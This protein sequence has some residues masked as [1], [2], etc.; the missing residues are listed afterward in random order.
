MWDL[1]VEHN[2]LYAGTHG[3]GL[4]KVPVADP[5]TCTITNLVDMGI[6]DCD[7]GAGTYSREIEIT[8]DYPFYTGTLDLLGQ[9]FEIEES[10]QIVRIDGLN[11]DG[12]SM[13]VTA[14]FSDYSCSYTVNTLFSNPNT[15]PCL[16]TQA[17]VDM[18]ICDDN[19]TTNPLDDF[20]SFSLD[21]TSVAAGS[22]YSVSG[23]VIEN[24]ISYGSPFT[25]DNGG[26]GYSILGGNLN[27]TITDDGNG[28]CSLDTIILAPL[29][30]CSDNYLCVD[31]TPLSVDGTYQAIGPDQGGGGSTGNNANWFSYT[32]TLNGLI[33]ISSC[34]DFEDTYLRLH[35]G[36][37]GSLNLI[38]SN[39]NGC[40]T[41]SVLED[42]CLMAGTNYFIEWDDTGSSNP[43]EFEIEFNTTEYFEDLDGDG[44]GN[45]LASSYEC[46][47]PSGYVT[48]NM[49]CDDTD[50]LESPFQAWYLDADGDGYGS[51]NGI[52]YVCERP[53]GMFHYDELLGD[54][55]DDC[56]DSD[57]SINPGVYDYCGDGIDNDCNGFI[58]DFNPQ[59]TFNLTTQAEV[60]N[61]ITTYGPCSIVDGYLTIGDASTPS[62]ITDISGLSSYVEIVAWLVVRNNPNL[63]SLEGLHNI[64]K[65]DLLFLSDLPN[66]PDLQDLSSL[67][68]L[69]Q[70]LFINNLPLITEL[71]P[72]NNITNATLDFVEI[73][74]CDALVSL[75]GLEGIIQIG[76][77]S[78]PSHLV[79]RFND[80]LKSLGGL[81]NAELID[82]DLVQIMQ[83][84]MLAYCDYEHLCNYINAGNPN[85]TISV[86]ATG[87]I[88]PAEI[89]A[90]CA[91][92]S[93]Y[94]P[95]MDNDCYGTGSTGMTSLY[96]PDP[97]YALDNTDCDDNDPLEYPGQKWY[98]DADGDT[99]GSSQVIQC[100]RP[101]NGFLSNELNGNIF[102]DCDDTNPNVNP[103]ML[104]ICGNGIDENC[105]GID[106]ICC[107][108]WDVI[109]LTQM[110]VDAFVTNYSTC[111]NI[112]GNLTIGPNSGLSDI[113]DLSG[114]SFLTEI[115]GNVTIQNNGSLPDL[116]G[117]EN[118]TNID[119][120]LSLINNDLLLD[121]ASLSNVASIDGVLTIQDND[122]LVSLVG[123]EN[124]D[125]TTILN[126][127]ITGNPTLAYCD[128]LSVCDYV[129]G[130]GINTINANATGCNSS[131]EINTECS[132][133]LDYYAD[134]D[135]D[136][137]GDPA[138]AT[139]F[140]MTPGVAS[141]YVLD[142]TDCND[143]D[144]DEFPGQTW[145]IDV[146]GDS[147]GVSII[148]QCTQPTNGIAIT[149]ANGNGTDDCNDNDSSINPGAT[150]ICDDGIDQDCNP[151]NEV[152][153]PTTTV[154]LETQAE[155]DAFVA[156]YPH[157]T[158]LKGLSLGQL[159][160]STDIGDLSGLSF[161]TKIV[162]P[163]AL[164]L[165]HCDNLVSLN[166][167]E[168]I[169]EIY[170]LFRIRKNDLLVDLDVLSNGIHIKKGGIY[171]TDNDA[172]I[173]IS[174]LSN[175]SADNG[176]N[177]AVYIQSNDIL[178]NL[179]GLE[180]VT[181]VDYLKVFDNPG[182]SSMQGL[183][184]LHSITIQGFIDNNDNMTSLAGLESLVT[185]GSGG[186]FEGLHLRW[187]DAVTDISALSNV[188]DVSPRL[189]ISG[190]T[191]LN[192][193]IG[194]Q[195]L[196]HTILS[197]VKIDGNTLLS[198]CEVISICDYLGLNG[199]AVVNNNATYCNT[200]TEILNQCSVQNTYY[201][202]TDMDSFGDPNNSITFM[203]IP[204]PSGYV[205]D[206]TD[207]NDMD[208]N[209]YPGQTWYIDGDSDGFGGSTLV[210]C[211]RPTNGFLL[212][213]L[214]G[215]G[216]DDC[217]DTDPAINPN[218]IEICDGIDNNCDGMA[219]DITLNQWIGPSN[220]DWNSSVTNWSTGIIPSYC[221][222]VLIPAGYHITVQS[223]QTA[224][225]YTL[226]VQLG[227]TIDFQV[228][229]N[230]DIIV[231]Q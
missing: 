163:G 42:I 122:L 170:S 164:Q 108:T 120:H 214:T 64:N 218:G 167:L 148:I 226:E 209:E 140:A 228:G 30:S 145:F 123:L 217:D 77:T 8:F 1:K 203:G 118:L 37:C 116:D 119:G 139:P 109:L 156:T 34:L 150:E 41:Q 197:D 144:A 216:T 111:N 181:Q 227:A 191:A 199:V 54:G 194:L 74:D 207:C 101:A 138:T 189:W 223:G 157:C 91:I 51:E 130:N 178:P 211:V 169:T 195:N 88:T 196:D 114:L 115:I 26:A 81:H 19:T 213:E 20:Y 70:A 39:N 154:V 180:W 149:N 29:V 38:A 2:T 31:A 201:A 7:P 47:Q 231:G 82:L 117:L 206:N 132:V 219:D 208:A 63:T 93:T 83:N 73:K 106:D 179:V 152:C 185:V 160:N 221:D 113:T 100:E 40:T 104:E 129:A 60:D 48:N 121:F 192:S 137:Y 172:L 204:T 90:E 165:N 168:N 27:I 176:V 22:T 67:S 143:N 184:N 98:I 32:P 87:C 14:D 58:D 3:R 75:E 133:D 95:D 186:S 177:D 162:W 12:N 9:S 15:C 80:S 110:D 224:Q 107:P 171:I 50:P 6:V 103:G 86:N 89:T 190:N 23:D 161:L 76:D 183:N 78:N 202:D 153:C 94:Y 99:Y 135:G 43:F 147:Y 17:N 55:G 52:V 126:L 13:D 124:I 193:L 21:P 62:D 125:H 134:T 57:S 56:D 200:T 25:F 205:P 4:W 182:L 146:D 33:T 16:V 131:A 229:A 97:G 5:K 112:M 71:T 220:G 187:N 212:S 155:V 65:V 72:L 174:A 69:Q 92:T 225:A 175:F 151:N 136:G 59:G 85:I 61:F 127:V 198:Q 102:N 166:G 10:P 68:I 141:G 46:S 44:Y 49:D 84:P 215:T 173:S 24:N 36:S 142:N 18:I 79:I 45:P 96:G 105:D 11:M 158:E 159:N 188:T 53:L 28:N 66:L 222:D 128:I 210:Q 230:I 35:E